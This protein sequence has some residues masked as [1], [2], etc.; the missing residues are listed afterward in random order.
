MRR[1]KEKKGNWGD[2]IRRGTGY[3]CTLVPRTG[4]G[5]TRLW[6]YREWVQ[7]SWYPLYTITLQTRRNCWC[8]PTHNTTATRFPSPVVFIGKPRI[9]DHTVQLS[10]CA[11]KV[12]PRQTSTSG[13]I[14]AT[15]TSWRQYSNRVLYWILFSVGW[16]SVIMPQILQIINCC[17]CTH[18]RLLCTHS[19]FIMQ[20][21]YLIG[22]IK[23][24]ET[25]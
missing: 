1:G 2:V 12:R 5:Q 20:S 15:M 21:K 10:A 25:D 24:N 13:H 7:D 6:I 11:V 19:C 23:H 4:P 8:H 3:F 9:C 22:K 14:D 16:K 17:M 18:W